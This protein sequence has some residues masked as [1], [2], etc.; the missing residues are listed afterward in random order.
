MIKKVLP[1]VAL[2]I[3][4]AVGGLAYTFLRTPEEASAPI[5]AIPV[6]VEDDAAPAVDNEAAAEA[7]EVETEAAEADAAAET[8]AVAQPDEAEP[9]AAPAE[10]AG[11]GPAIFE[12]VPAESEVRFLIGEVL[13]GSPVT[14]VGAT[15]QVAAEFAVSADDL[16]ATQLGPILVNARTLV[17][18]NNFR[19]RAI[20]N[21]ILTTDAYEFITF[22]PT[23]IVGLSGSG[24]I[25][26]P[27]SFQ[28]IGDLTVRDV[29][30]PVTFEATATALSDSEI[31]GFATTTILYPDYNLAI[32]DVPQVASVEDE[33]VL[34]IDFVAAAKDSLDQG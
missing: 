11:I 1:L 9:E 6:V 3:I 23:E 7:S 18:D 26:E 13:R 27:Y 21:R 20:K 29:T 19:N 30:N 17:T 24:A 25:G 8:E 28:I 5:E 2:L 33:V 16:A 4:V 12:I 32:P 34:E 10:T 31:K 14:V 22:T 15:D